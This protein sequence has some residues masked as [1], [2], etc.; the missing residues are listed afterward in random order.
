VFR[1]AI[2]LAEE[3]TDAKFE[4]EQEAN[5]SVIIRC[6]GIGYT[7]PQASSSSEEVPAQEKEP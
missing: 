5:G 3:L 1:T 4:V 6:Q 7:A 2:W